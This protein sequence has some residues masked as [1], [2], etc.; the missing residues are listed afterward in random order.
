[1]SGSHHHDP[2][3]DNIDT[4]PVKLAIGVASGASRS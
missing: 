1:M 3:E 4:H 2:I